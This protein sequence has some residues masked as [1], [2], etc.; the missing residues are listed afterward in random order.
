MT[1][2]RK[3]E[4]RK[5]RRLKDLKEPRQVSTKEMKSTAGGYFNNG[6]SGILKTEP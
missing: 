3:T 5:S 2:K 4:K 1:R 6:S